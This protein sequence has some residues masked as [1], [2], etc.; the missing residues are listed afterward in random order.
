[1][2]EKGSNKAR[3]MLIKNY[4]RGTEQEEKDLFE[5]AKKELE[6]CMKEIEYDFKE[7][8]ELTCRSNLSTEENITQKGEE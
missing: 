7:F 4:L 8:R 1:M 2:A 5:Q 6:V 3:D